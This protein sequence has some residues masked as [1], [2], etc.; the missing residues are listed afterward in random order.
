MSTT[1]SALTKGDPYPVSALEIDV[2]GAAGRDQ[3]V[4]LAHPPP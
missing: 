1:E 2:P 3:H 4:R